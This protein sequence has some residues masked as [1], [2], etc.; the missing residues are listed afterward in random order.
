M[1]LDWM[2]KICGII[3]ANPQLRIATAETP[4]PQITCGCSRFLSAEVRLL[5]RM[6]AASNKEKHFAEVLLRY[7]RL[8]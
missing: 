3:Y 2:S 8:D 5:G 6:N 1:V 4:F 7:L